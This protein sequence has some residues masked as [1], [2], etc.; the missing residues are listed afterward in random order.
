MFVSRCSGLK[1][2]IVLGKLQL[3]RID[4]MVVQS[5]IVG[6]KQPRYVTL[7]LQMEQALLVVSVDP[8]IKFDRFFTFVYA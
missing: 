7:V 2:H 3:D 1:Y 4:T 5:L 6:I 8:L